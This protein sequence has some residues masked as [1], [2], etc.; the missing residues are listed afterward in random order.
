MSMKAIKDVI[1][2]IN[3]LRPAAYTSTAGATGAW[4]DLANVNANKI[5]IEVGTIT[6]G[7]HTPTVE[8]STDGAT[9][10]G[11]VVA[12]DLVGA[13]NV[14]A[15]NADQSVSYIGSARWVRVKVTITGATTGG[16][17]VAGAQVEYRKQP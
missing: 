5:Y 1:K 3:T 17:Y 10:A 8:Y 7:V 9:L 11:T 13:F 14:L 4:I 2:R 15:S 16:I 12:T 6:D